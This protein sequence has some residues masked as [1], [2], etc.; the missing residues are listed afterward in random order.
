MYVG[1][2]VLTLLTTKQMRIAGA[3]VSRPDSKGTHILA[4]WPAGLLATAACVGYPRYLRM[5]GSNT[6]PGFSGGDEPPPP[7]PEEDPS[8]RAARTVIGRE[9]HLRARPDPL[10]KASLPASPQAPTG[11]PETLI[12]ETTEEIPRRPSHSGKSKLPA[13]ARLFGRWTTGGGFLARSRLSRVDDDLLNV[14]RD[15]WAFRVAMF[16]VAA[17]LSFLVALA[18]LKV[19]QC[20][21]SVVSPSATAQASVSAIPATPTAASAAPPV[22]PAAPAPQP[23]AAASQP[24]AAT[25]PAARAAQPPAVRPRTTHRP[26]KAAGGFSARAAPGATGK[27]RT[28]PTRPGP[29]KREDPY[30]DAL[31]PLNL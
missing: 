5:S 4:G 10:P 22:L 30:R 29:L 17:L 2:C 24:S 12:E 9:I 23:L 16:V 7:N 31:L 20:G 19:H 6:R 28:Q 11:V 1:R 15:P 8:P 3:R 18:V 26:A 27:L 14:P 25:A 21:T 13:L